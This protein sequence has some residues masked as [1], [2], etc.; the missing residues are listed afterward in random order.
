M[1]GHKTRCT[2]ENR[3]QVQ[4]MTTESKSGSCVMAFTTSL[5][6][7]GLKREAVTREAARGVPS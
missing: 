5:L 4:V 6:L 7:G 2:N 1:N 3:R